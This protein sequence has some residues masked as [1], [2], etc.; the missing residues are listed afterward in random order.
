MDNRKR[1]YSARSNSKPYS[2]PASKAEVKQ[3]I[4]S[5][6]QAEVEDKYFLFNSLPTAV[7]FNGTT[8]DLLLVP[9]GITDST[10]IGDE[11]RLTSISL[12]LQV[13]G[14][15]ATNL[16][17]V[18]IFKWRP[19]TVASVAAILPFA[20][21]SANAPLSPYSR[22]RSV[23]YKVY[24]DRTFALSTATN[25][26]QVVKFHNIPVKGLCQYQSGTTTGTNHLYLLVISD[27]GAAP[28]PSINY[29]TRVNFTDA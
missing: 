20:L 23:D 10:R 12:E 27:S 13:I 8:Q 26:S 16:M 24:F 6:M 9:Q 2:K 3:M 29:M 25:V 1:K 22:D 21:A 7:D 17:R 14:V 15:D 19:S 18:I 5:V 11:I 28:N 4:K